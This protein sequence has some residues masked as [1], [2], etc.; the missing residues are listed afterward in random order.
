MAEE[1]ADVVVSLRVGV[2]ARGGG[3]HVDGTR[4]VHREGVGRAGFIHHPERGNGDGRG[5]GDVHRA[6]DRTEVTG[7]VSLHRRDGEGPVE[8]RE[9]RRVAVEDGGAA[10]D[11]P[12]VMVEGAL[13]PQREG[14]APSED[15]AE[16]HVARCDGDVLAAVDVAELEA[17]RK[18]VQRPREGDGV[19]VVNLEGE[20]RGG[21][22]GDGVEV[23]TLRDVGDGDGVVLGVFPVRAAGVRAVGQLDIGGALLFQEKETTVTAAGFPGSEVDQNRLFDTGVD[24]GNVQNRG[25]GELAGR[26]P[27]AVVGGGSVIGGPGIPRFR[28]DPETGRGALS[29]PGGNPPGR[30]LVPVSA[31]EEV[32]ARV[33]G[34]LHLDDLDRSD[35]T[36]EILA[37][38]G[39]RAP[40]RGLDGTH[41]AGTTLDADRIDAV[42][43]HRVAGDPPREDRIGG[44]D[45]VPEGVV[46]AI[47]DSVHRDGG[48]LD[49]VIIAGGVDHHIVGVEGDAVDGDG[50][51]IAVVQVIFDEV[52]CDAVRVGVKV[53]GGPGCG[54]VVGGRIV[55]GP[56]GDIRSVISGK[57]VPGVTD[58]PFDQSDLLTSRHGRIVL[59]CAETHADHIR[60][61]PAGQRENTCRQP[62]HH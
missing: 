32:G 1:D 7:T 39:V 9:V 10:G 25:E 40:G 61:R 59:V 46:P 23:V 42:R 37:R 18:G 51:G 47:E 41:G 4:K 24:I 48:E 8:E 2:V 57:V 53:R 19:H 11:G 35:R 43:R 58:H 54:E 44:R 13:F 26:R 17:S 36:A 14:P 22:E 16:A 20:S 15:A 12:Q 62:T 34:F 29:A 33:G 50:D 5:C 55:A 45:G 28:S 60:H 6:A 56:Q 30:G 31:K 27:A 3:G 21:G 52:V 49:I 38:G